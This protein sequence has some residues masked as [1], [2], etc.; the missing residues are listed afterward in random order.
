[1]KSTFGIFTKGQG[2]VSFG[3]MKASLVNNINDPNHPD[4]PASPNR[5]RVGTREPGEVNPVI[6]DPG[7]GQIGRWQTV[8]LDSLES[9]IDQIIEQYLRDKTWYSNVRCREALWNM[10]KRLAWWV[11]QQVDPNRSDYQRALLLIKDCIRHI[12]EEAQD[13]E[14]AHNVSLPTCPAPFYFPFNADYF[15][16]FDGNDVERT[17]FDM[18]ALPKSDD[19][20]GLFRYVSSVEDQEWEIVHSVGSNE[21][22]GNENIMKIALKQ[23]LPGNSSKVTFNWRWKRMGYISFKYWAS[24]A[25]GNG[26]NFFINNN[27][28]GGEWS[29][30]TGWQEVKFNVAPGQTYKFDWL[31]RKQVGDQFGQNAVY[32]K[33][34]KCIE[35]IRSLG[36][37]TPP[38]FD[39]MGSEAYGI[40]GFEWTTWSKSSVVKTHFNGVVTDENRAR[41]LL[42]HLDNECDGTVRFAYRMGTAQPGVA[43]ERY[44]MFSD[45]LKDYFQYSQGKRGSSVSAAHDPSWTLDGSSSTTQTN[46][47]KIAYSLV[48]GEG[49]TVDAR[50][51]I[52]MV[53]PPLEIDHYEDSVL[54]TIETANWSQSGNLHWQKINNSSTYRIDNPTEGSGALQTVLYLE[55][56]GWFE[57]SFDHSLRPTER[58]EVLVDQKV[59]FESGNTNSGQNIYIPLNQGQR[60]ISFQ[61]TDTYTEEGITATTNLDY[62]YGSATKGKSYTKTG[63]FE[64]EFTITRNWEMSNAG[65]FTSQ[66]GSQI[67]YTV[68]LNPGASFEVEEMLQLTAPLNE[69]PD[70]PIFE[71]DF[72]KSDGKHDPRISMT[73][74]WKWKDILDYA[75]P[76]IGDGVYKV[77]G[78]DN[79]PNTI[80]LSGVP[81][82]NDGVLEFEYGGKFG[83]KENLVLTIDGNVVW[84]D[85]KTETSA[86]GNTV[87]VPVKAGNHTYQWIYQYLG[88]TTYIDPEAEGTG[89]PD[90]G[91]VSYL[92]GSL[93]QPIVYGQSDWTLLTDRHSRMRSGGTHF[94]TPLSQQEQASSTNG[95][96]ITRNF[97]FNSYADV[98][99]YEKLTI[100]AGKD[101]PQASRIKQ[102]SVGISRKNDPNGNLFAG[103]G[104][105]CLN[106]TGVDPGEGSGWAT[107]SFYTHGWINITFDLLAYLVDAT[108]GLVTSDNRNKSGRDTDHRGEFS[109]HIV[110]VGGEATK[111]NQVYQLLEN[112]GPQDNYKDITA[113]NKALSVPPIKKSVPPG[114]YYVYFRMFDAIADYDKDASGLPY[115]AAFKNFSLTGSTAP[116]TIPN[117]VDDT[118]VKVDLLDISNGSLVESYT[119]GTEGAVSRDIIVS[120]GSLQPG[121]AYQVRYTLLKGEGTTGGLNGNGG[122]MQLSSGWFSETWSPYCRD[123]NGSY[124][125]PGN[126]PYPPSPNTPP[127][128]LPA[129]DGSYCWIDVIKL[130]QSNR[131]VCPGTGLDVVV[132]SGGSLISQHVYSSPSQQE[133]TVS[134]I[135][136]TQTAKTYEI[137]M[138]FLAGCSGDK[139]SM[140]KGKYKLVD[141]SIIMPSYAQITGFRATNHKP[142][143]MGG[144]YTSKIHVRVYNETGTLVYSTDF[145]GGGLDSFLVSKLPF[146]PYSKYRVEVE[147]EQGGQISTVTGKHYMTTFKLLDFT[148]YENWVFVP[149]PFKGKLE[150]FID[151]TLVDTYTNQ[152]GFYDVSYPVP[153]G[154]HEFKWV[155]TELGNGYSWDYCDIDL[156]ELT[157]WVCDRVRVT[158]YCEKGGG[159]KCVEELIKCLLKLWQDRPKAC[160]IGRKIWLF[161]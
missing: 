4:N 40:P 30:G 157:N 153:K 13:P 63:P 36:G 131:T 160:S 149:D 98:S 130:Y 42:Y 106:I 115:Y 77:V 117:S 89:A 105:Y 102:L 51:T 91:E 9:V 73:P 67:N 97:S 76:D 81:L 19:F 127:Q 25:N 46:Q 87:K 161:T 15:N 142:I 118:S 14:L 68:T 83:L 16:H 1:M 64:S 71:E 126:S 143:W 57:F 135:N 38:D 75:D 49:C 20:H 101:I 29:D 22:K 65:T 50:G 119:Y 107:A 93:K 80:T 146:S 8:N 43:S 58:L 7:K 41:T 5:P 28:V 27:Q 137:S 94:N 35:V 48:V 23:L 52:E 138:R 108:G 18:T 151:S 56:D 74:N 37:D 24:A 132:T 32:I 88:G 12:L 150:F 34:V 147:T 62:S 60:F 92:A 84:A 136:S 78:K 120:F 69:N 33:D 155:F 90:S 116:S 123:K 47:A 85:A 134:L 79:F 156:L 11:K 124:Y 159:D 82:T 21:T 95:A 66:D 122:S 139:A 104:Y 45:N 152:G 128:T 39:T 31:V 113:W 96:T 133:V 26:L 125:S 53:C 112:I 110:P 145:I 109:V 86:T 2:Q 111:G 158:P 59:V 121:R 3:R 114:N 140:Y 141:K 6:G 70:E 129:N 61:I 99:F 44:W 148:A 100:Q 144:C 103:N 17:L 54:Q 72:N 55:D 154:A 10:Y